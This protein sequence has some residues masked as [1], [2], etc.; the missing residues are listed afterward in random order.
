MAVRPGLSV[1]FCGIFY[2]IRQHN[3]GRETNAGVRYEN[4]V[5]ARNRVSY[6]GTSFTRAGNHDFEKKTNDGSLASSNIFLAQDVRSQKAAQSTREDSRAFCQT[7]ETI[8]LS[9]PVGKYSAQSRQQQKQDGMY[10]KQRAPFGHTHFKT[11]K[12]EDAGEKT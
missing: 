1:G 10:N 5:K 4:M 3:K 2:I 12:K 8:L 11:A 7:T 9:R 6:V